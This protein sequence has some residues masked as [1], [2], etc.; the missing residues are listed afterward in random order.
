MVS[1]PRKIGTILAVVHLAVAIVFAIWIYRA[2]A[3]DGESP[4][5]WL[6]LMLIDLPAVFLLKP[7]SHVVHGW[8]RV[9]WLPGL[10]GD[11]PNFLFPLLS[12]IIIGTIWWFCLGWLCGR[13]W[14]SIRPRQ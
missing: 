4:M 8:P 2:N 3:H 11:W 13:I 14:T 6:F 1:T 7:L 9:G 10:A 5:Y 12:L